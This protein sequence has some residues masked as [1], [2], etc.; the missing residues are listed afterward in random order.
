[1]EN[2]GDLVTILTEGS[3]QD[4]TVARLQSILYSTVVQ[5]TP[6]SSFI[7]CNVLRESLSVD[8]QFS[9]LGSR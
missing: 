3:M 6:L 8:C 4:N 5:Q 1:M 2:F 9:A 7:T